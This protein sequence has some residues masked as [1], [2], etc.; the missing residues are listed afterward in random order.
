[1]ASYSSPHDSQFFTRRVITFAI[2]VG[3]QVLIVVLLGT[4]LASRVINIVAPPIQ[5]DIVQEVQK[6]DEAPPP[7][8]PK[9]ERPPVEVPPPDVAINIP[10]ETRTTAITNTTDKPVKRAPPPAPAPRRVVTRPA[11][12]ARNFP[13][14][15]DYYPP[16][17]Q[18]LNEEGTT[19]MESCVGPNGQLVQEPKVLKSSGHT[20][21]DE[22]AV[23]LAK[24]G[25]YV[26]EAV[27][28]KPVNSC[29]K[30]N[31]VWRLQ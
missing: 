15:Q 23:R 1:M 13:N 6:H 3:V 2:A 20:R 26:P 24:A 22:A 8:P 19:L 27:D 17:S 16:A 4:G 7:P 12:L 18:R 28:G 14:S 30:F 29:I 10:A 31:V 9:M 25:R 11:A 5:T 21:L